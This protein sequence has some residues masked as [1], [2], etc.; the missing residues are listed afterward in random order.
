M[1]MTENVICDDLVLL[2]VNNILLLLLPLKEHQVAR[3]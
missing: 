1:G 2:L 3:Y